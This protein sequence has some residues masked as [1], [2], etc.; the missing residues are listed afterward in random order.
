MDFDG[1]S[2]KDVVSEL[3]RYH[4]API[5]FAEGQAGR[6]RLGGGFS[7][8]NIDQLFRPLPHVAAV[9]VTFRADGIATIAPR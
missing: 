7:I 6:A 3:G 8:V 4:V 1:A 5:V 2:L 9:N